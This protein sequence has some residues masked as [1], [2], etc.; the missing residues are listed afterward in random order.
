MYIYFKA[1]FLF[2]WK[3]FQLC[4]SLLSCGLWWQETEAESLPKDT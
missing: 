3:L 1:Q 2:S 4:I